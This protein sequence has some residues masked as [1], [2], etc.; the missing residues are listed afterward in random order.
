MLRRE[1]ELVVGDK[2]RVVVL[3]V[4]EQ[5]WLIGVA[6]GRVSLLHSFGEQA[7]A[8]QLPAELARDT[9]AATPSFAQQLRRGLGMSS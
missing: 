8:T 7:V 9:I 6:P 4:G 3:A 2:E 1:A 5:R